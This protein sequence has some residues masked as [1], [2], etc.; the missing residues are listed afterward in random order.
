MTKKK[1]LKLKY[2]KKNAID[3]ESED[4]DTDEEREKLIIMLNRYKNSTRFGNYLL[5]EMKITELNNLERN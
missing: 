3:S 4:D 1:K 2:Q 5:K